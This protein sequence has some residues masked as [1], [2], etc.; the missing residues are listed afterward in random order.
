ML[1]SITDLAVDIFLITI[2]LILILAVIYYG[3]T[4]SRLN[5]QNTDLTLCAGD[6]YDVLFVRL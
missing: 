1:Q 2:L 3:K 4:S 5:F 6:T